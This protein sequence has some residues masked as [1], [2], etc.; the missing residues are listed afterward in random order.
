[1][2]V[3]APEHDILGLERGDQASDNVLHVVSPFR[4]PVS[5]QPVHPD[6]LLE[7]S[8]PVWQMAELHRLHDA[9]D[10]HRRA[11]SG[12]QP[13]KEHLAAAIATERLHRGVVDDL[14]RTRE[15][16]PI[17]ESNPARAEVTRLRDW[18]AVE[19]RSRIA[20]RDRVITPLG[21]DGLGT[22]YH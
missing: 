2:N 6:I 22:V 5:L 17:V 9:V 12:A 15:R 13:E 10:D 3:T 8:V 21:C 19:D 18:A 7:R 20:D 4:Q 1:M 16:G 11:Q 14:D